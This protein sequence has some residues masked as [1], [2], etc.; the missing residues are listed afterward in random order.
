MTEQPTEEEL[1]LRI[2]LGENDRHGHI[3]LYE[4]LVECLRREGIA[5]A[6][7]LRGVAGFGGSRAFHADKL[8]DLAHDLPLVIEAVDKR[9]RLEAALPAIRN[10]LAGGLITLET[11]TVI[12]PTTT[13]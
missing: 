9:E 1:L 7:V 12:R 10:M 11:V 4:A 5:G 2:Y 3:P 8:L 6:T 13:H